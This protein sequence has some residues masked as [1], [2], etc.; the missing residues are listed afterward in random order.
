[1]RVAEQAFASGNGYVFLVAD[2]SAYYRLG[3]DDD[4]AVLVT[5]LGASYMGSEPVF[6]GAGTGIIVTLEDGSY[7]RMRIDDSGDYVADEVEIDSARWSIDT[8]PALSPEGDILI[9][10]GFGAGA[11]C[12]TPD[13]T[14]IYR[15]RLDIDG[16]YVTE[17]FS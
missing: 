2:S 8:D 9:I 12:T 13:G 6:A 10:G 4:G 7:A 14:N 16:A 5:G 15:M 17:L 3:V 1:M 11:L